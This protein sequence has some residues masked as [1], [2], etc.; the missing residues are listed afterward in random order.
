MTGFN[1]KPVTDNQYQMALFKTIVNMFNNSS[2]AVFYFKHIHGDDLFEFDSFYNRFAIKTSLLTA[3]FL[4]CLFDIH[5]QALCDHQR[6]QERLK[7]L[8]RSK[9]DE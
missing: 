1:M 2:E 5:D 9:D 8:T 4:K 6:K 3:H 7:L